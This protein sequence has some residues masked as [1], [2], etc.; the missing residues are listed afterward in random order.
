MENTQ[1]LI[2][3]VKEGSKT[4]NKIVDTQGI[5]M[6]CAIKQPIPVQNQ[7]GSMSMIEHSCNSQ[8]IFFNITI[9]DGGFPYFQCKNSQMD[10]ELVLIYQEKSQNNPII[11][12]DL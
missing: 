9:K 5:E 1:H 10:E 4:I 6:T 7:L 8:C 11:I 12:S 3:T 2:K